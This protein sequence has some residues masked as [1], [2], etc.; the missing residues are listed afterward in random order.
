MLLVTASDDEG[1]LGE[2]LAAASVL[3][4][5]DLSPES[6]SPALAIGL[7]NADEYRIRFC[8]PLVRS[9]VLQ[10]ASL[11]E[12]LAAHGALAAVLDGQSDRRT[13]H[14]A[15]ASGRHDESV[16]VELD[17]TA[18]RAET[19]GAPAVA[20]AALERSIALSEVH[21][22][23]AKRLLKAAE[24]ALELGRTDQAAA[25]LQLAAPLEVDVLVRAR[26]VLL[27]EGLEIDVSRSIPR[28]HLLITTAEEAAAAGDPELALRLLRAAATRCWW[29]NPGRVLRER[30]VAAAERLPVPEL[31]PD[32]VFVLAGA[33]PL[34]RGATV[35]ERLERL[36][37]E[38]GYDAS[39][40]TTL[41]TAAT[42]VG[43]YDHG[44]GFL[45]Q[46]RPVCGPRDGWDSSPRPWCPCRTPRRT[47][48][49]GNRA[50]RAWPRPSG[51]RRSTP[52]LA[53]SPVHSSRR[54]NSRR[55]LGILKRRRPPT[56]RLN[57]RESLRRMPAT[58]PSSRSRE[59]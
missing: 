48:W 5:S 38:G 40:A 39:A 25:L 12:R 30:V 31:H 52:G 18:A 46:G 17:E 37:R 58:S 33:T 15:A 20:L 47:S 10:T 7:V 22:R 2:V 26:M 4:G 53:G 49:T 16:A 8:H 56:D 34:E 21:S 35:I 43:G 57:A 1:A 45:R 50:C 11:A 28:L 6:L 13:W 23:R 24:L 42:M 41:G 55:Y 9:A 51:S 3:A 32:L 19:R 27:S 54:P 36:E 29:D 14:R 44:A 59:A